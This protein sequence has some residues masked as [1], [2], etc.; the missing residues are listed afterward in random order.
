MAHWASKCNMMHYR[1]TPI[2]LFIPKTRH[3]PRRIR[4]KRRNS[5]VVC[6]GDVPEKRWHG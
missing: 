5:L 6:G 2:F 4:S 3:Q 1:A